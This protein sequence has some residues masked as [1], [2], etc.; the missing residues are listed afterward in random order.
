MLS[1]ALMY[2]DVFIRVQ[3]HEP[4]YKCLPDDSEWELATMM[5]EHLQLFYKLTEHFSGIFFLQMNN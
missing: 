3:Q 2:K 4:Q 5:V 1:V